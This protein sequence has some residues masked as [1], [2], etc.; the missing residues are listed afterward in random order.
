MRM[1][2]CQQCSEVVRWPA[3]NGYRCPEC[4]QPGTEDTSGD[5]FVHARLEFDGKPM[6]DGVYTLETGGVRIRI[7]PRTI[8]LPLG[9]RFDPYA[10]CRRL[11]ACFEACRR[12]PTADLESGA[13]ADLLGA[14]LLEKDRAELTAV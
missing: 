13:V 9:D 2:E 10:F 3:A 1:L 6:D 14:A 12:L 4:H 7:E 8:R 11:A 5:L